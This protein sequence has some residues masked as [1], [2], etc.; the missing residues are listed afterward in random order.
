MEALRP[1]DRVYRVPAC[2][3][4]CGGPVALPLAPCL[5][6]RRLVET[7]RVC[8]SV[9]V[10]KALVKM[11]MLM[12]MKMLEVR[13]MALAGGW[14]ALRAPCSEAACQQ[15]GSAVAPDSAEA[16]HQGQTSSAP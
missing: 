11:A 12:M 13:S 9:A 5:G 3:G 2:V 1:R 15:R 10:G 16:S 6:E 14:V 8:L 4:S 7:Y